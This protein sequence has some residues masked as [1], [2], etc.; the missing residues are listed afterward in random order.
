M[1]LTTDQRTLI[2]QFVSEYHEEADRL[3]PYA[4]IRRGVYRNVARFLEGLLRTDGM[5]R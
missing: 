2:R 4:S 3:S 1:T 5:H